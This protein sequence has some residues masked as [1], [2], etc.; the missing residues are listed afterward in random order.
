MQEQQ[1]GL[2]RQRASIK[3]DRDPF[4]GIPSLPEGEFIPVI[5]EP[6]APEKK[7]WWRVFGRRNPQ[8]VEESK[9]EEPESQYSYSLEQAYLLGVFDD[10]AYRRVNR[11]T[12][13]SQDQQRHIQEVKEG[14]FFWPLN[15]L[16][17]DVTIG[18]KRVEAMVD[19]D[20]IEA[21]YFLHFLEQGWIGLQ[22]CHKQLKLLA[23]QQLVE[24]HKQL[25]RT[26]EKIVAKRQE[27]H[28]AS[29][30]YVAVEW[31]EHAKQM[32]K[33]E[34]REDWMRASGGRT[35]EEARDDELVKVDERASAP[36]ARLIEQIDLIKPENWGSYLANPVVRVHPVAAQIVLELTFLKS[37]GINTEILEGAYEGN[38]NRLTE[39]AQEL[40]STFIIHPPLSLDVP[41]EE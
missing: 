30:S 32:Y 16:L 26:W 10:G 24:C 38:W 39:K 17:S 2:P 40:G 7:R 36:A 25:R 27:K 37:I 12:T 31:Y 8:V 9:T 35:P 5:P 23:Q 28:A 4:I 13:A 11:G 18:I 41:I 20:P 22:A 3:S 34:P 15:S 6:P 21:A 1:S 19:K 29:T 14:K 33:E